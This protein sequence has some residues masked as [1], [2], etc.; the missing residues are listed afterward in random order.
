MSLVDIVEDCLRMVRSQDAL[1]RALGV[2]TSDLRRVLQR[3]GTTPTLSP[4]AVIR[5]ARLTRRNTCAA[6][7]EAG[8]IALAGELESLLEDALSP[9]HQS[10]LDDL[11][12]LPPDTRRHFIDLIASLARFERERDRG[13]H[14]DRE[15]TARTRPRRTRATGTRSSEPPRPRGRRGP[16]R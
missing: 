13:S 5:A 8:E 9:A 3:N 4:A 6:L 7:R 10:I 1:A 11:S 14:T 2:P 16:N 15:G 12:L